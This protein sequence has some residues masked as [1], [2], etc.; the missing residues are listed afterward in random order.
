VCLHFKSGF[1][2]LFEKTNGVKAPGFW[3]L[4]GKW[5]FKTKQVTG[6]WFLVLIFWDCGR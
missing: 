6:F 1:G 5:F 3:E 4:D 2:I